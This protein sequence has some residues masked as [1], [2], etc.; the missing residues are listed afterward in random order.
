MKIYRA[1]ERV[2]PGTYKQL[3]SARVVRLE[4]EDYLP[5]SLNG[6]VACFERV[7][8]SW[9]ELLLEYASYPPPTTSL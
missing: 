1:G 3:N 6:R 2:A 9:E 8:S 4:Q 7:E 5:A